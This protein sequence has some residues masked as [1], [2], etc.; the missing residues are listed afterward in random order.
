MFI[1]Q[2]WTFLKKVVNSNL[3]SPYIISGFGSLVEKVF[4]ADMIY[5]Q[6]SDGLSVV[7]AKKLQTFHLSLKSPY[8]S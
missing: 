2:G 6:P 8:I 3:A 5:F 7:E 1:L 4:D